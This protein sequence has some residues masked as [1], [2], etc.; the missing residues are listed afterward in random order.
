MTREQNPLAFS[1]TVER[2]SW[3]YLLRTYPGIRSK[4]AKYIIRLLQDCDGAAARDH[5]G[6]SMFDAIRVRRLFRKHSNPGGWSW[7]LCRQMA[8]VCWKYRG[9]LRGAGIDYPASLFLQ[10]SQRVKT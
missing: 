2:A 9:Q 8:Q 3:L 7:F 10:E 1:P 6:F 5:K 4:L